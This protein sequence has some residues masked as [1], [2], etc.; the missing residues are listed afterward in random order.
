MRTKNLLFILCGMLAL[1]S[2][3]GCDDEPTDNG[4][5]GRTTVTVTE[6]LSGNSGSKTD[7]VVAPASANT[8][9]LEGYYFVEAGST[10]T[11]PAGTTVKASSAVPSAIIVQRGTADEP[12]G[13][14]I[15][16]GNATNPIV[17]TSDLAP[18]SR[19]RG[20]WGGIVLQ[21]LADLNLD[22]KSGVA[23]GVGGSYGY[24]GVLS[25]AKN[26]DNSGTLKYVRIEYGGIKV[27]TDNEI[28][29]LTLNAVGNGT[30]I[31]HVQSHMIADDGFEWFGGTVNAKYLVSSGNDDDAFDMDF[32]YSGNLQF[33][34]AMQD[35][36]LANRGFEIDNDGDGSTKTPFTSATVA[37]V[38]IV[39]TGK[40]KA[41]SED[42][43]GFYLRR[44]NKLN[45]WNAISTNFRYAMVIDGATTGQHVQ[46]GELFV[47]QSILNGRSGPYYAKGD[48]G[49]YTSVAAGWSNVTEDPQLAG[50]NFS[51][52][53]PRPQNS[54]AANI[55]NVPNNG[56]FTSNTYAGAFDPSSSSYWFSGWTNWAKN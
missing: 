22:S 34:F 42:N 46:N 4:N 15:A 13:K 16:E 52:P 36:D 39:G 24:G 8:I 44:S 38:T 11:I 41:N 7:V 27:T 14:I 23:E 18:G 20:N 53:Q 29:G 10:L 56:F 28:N 17:F 50:I 32:G 26:D 6:K 47:K 21:G 45:I 2:V 31:E 25:A 33:L 54:K 43:D 35:P 49:D 40:D 19:G 12:S 9:T 48:A 37:N 3:V 51:N 5:N 30:T 1:S 55:G